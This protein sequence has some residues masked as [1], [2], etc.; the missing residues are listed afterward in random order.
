[1]LQETESKLS[2]TSGSIVGGS[3]VGDDDC[4]SPSIVTLPKSECGEKLEYGEKDHNNNDDVIAE[5]L[6]LKTRCT[7]QAEKIKFLEKTNEILLR[8][9]ENK[10]FD[11]AENQDE[12]EEK[13]QEIYRLKSLI[14]PKLIESMSTTSLVKKT[15]IIPVPSAKS[16]SFIA[17]SVSTLPNSPSPSVKSPAIKSSIIPQRVSEAQPRA[18]SLT[19][20]ETERSSADSYAPSVCTIPNSPAAGSV[21]VFSMNHQQTEWKSANDEL[22]KRYTE[23]QKS[24]KRRSEDFQFEINELKDDIEDKNNEICG[25]NKEL[26]MKNTEN[27]KLESKL[28][29]KRA[30]IRSIESESRYRNEKSLEGFESKLNVLRRQLETE[31]GNNNKLQKQNNEMKNKLETKKSEMNKLH[32]QV[33]L[34]NKTLASKGKIARKNQQRDS[35]RDDVSDCGSSRSGSVRSG[36]SKKFDFNTPSLVSKASA[37]ASVFSIIPQPMK[38][39][40]QLTRNSSIPASTGTLGSS[41]IPLPIS[42]SNQISKTP[43]IPSTPAAESQSDSFDFSKFSAQISSLQKTKERKEMEIEELKGQFEDQQN[44]I[45]Q[46]KK[47]ISE[48]KEPTQV[49]T[50]PKQVVTGILDASEICS[51]SIESDNVDDAESEIATDTDQK[52]VKFLKKKLKASEKL[53]KMEV[54]KSMDLQK[55][56]DVLTKK[57]ELW[58]IECKSI[59]CESAEAKA[60]HS[61]MVNQIDSMVNT[62]KTLEHQVY[63]EK[64][65]VKKLS[66]NV[67]KLL[68]IQNSNTD[69]NSKNESDTSVPKVEQQNNLQNNKLQ[70]YNKFLLGKLEQMKQEMAI[71][72]DMVKGH[73]SDLEITLS[74]SSSKSADVGL[75]NE[76]QIVVRNLHLTF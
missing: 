19:R 42:R 74:R 41:I 58:K 45:S 46:L 14:E 61:L 3:I 2:V 73:R 49:K 37:T 1:V 23:L 54:K 28:E 8:K 26:E 36:T 55:I 43:S 47:I 18:F 60:E 20:T 65:Q 7:E 38:R 13:T 66:A 17:P 52:E 30:E 21:S 16:F 44:Q 24:Y 75:Q 22:K 70:T 40:D 10:D 6:I 48:R 62:N 35:M 11:L 56:N 57:V 63:T 51:E 12:M 53:K 59:E 71:Y 29:R 39:S 9:V 32:T 34:A 72:K 27:I 25:K 68:E 33:T 67:E 69:S 76:L 50:V 4:F 64:Q 5:K 31:T 15:S